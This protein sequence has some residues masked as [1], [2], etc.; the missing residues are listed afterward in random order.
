MF[1]TPVFCSAQEYSEVVQI[2]GKTADQLYTSSRE[3]FALFFKS[4]DDV[5]QMDDPIAQKLIGK[6]N[7]Y[8]KGSSLVNWYVNLTINITCRD[9]RFKCD[10]SGITVSREING[11]LLDGDEDFKIYQNKKEYFK[12]AS[13]PEWIKKNIKKHGMIKAI[14]AI[15]GAYYNLIVDTEK[16]LAGIP[17][18][19]KKHASKVDADW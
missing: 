10:L 8:I 4:A 17:T 6:G 5:L 15:N 19:L 2:P 9:G 11:K 14:A 7:L 1:L 16:A 18:S 12:N 13:D 3:W